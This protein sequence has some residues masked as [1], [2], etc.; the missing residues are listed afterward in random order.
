MRVYKVFPIPH[1]GVCS[2]SRRWS[3]GVHPAILWGAAFYKIGKFFLHLS[4]CIENGLAF[5]SQTLIRKKS[6]ISI[7]IVSLSH[8]NRPF[9][10]T[11]AKF[12]NYST[13]IRSLICWDFS[14]TMGYTNFRWLKIFFQFFFIT[15]QMTSLQISPVSHGGMEVPWKMIVSLRT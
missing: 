2:H 10:I 12:Y 11:P 3:E 6:V 4:K 15:L 1:T 9:G 13:T 5:W 8:H 14:V 7:T